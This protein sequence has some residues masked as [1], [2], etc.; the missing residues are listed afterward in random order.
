MLLWCR[1]IVGVH[2]F[3]NELIAHT[4]EVLPQIISEKRRPI[5][6]RYRSLFFVFHCHTTTVPH[7]QGP[8]KG[9]REP[10]AGVKT[11]GDRHVSSD[12][13]EQ[14]RNGERRRRPKAKASAKQP[15]EAAPGQSPEGG[16]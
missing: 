3:R 16:A 5:L 13:Q 15:D 7:F 6:R 9:S 8:F 4:F 10:I 2:V 14:E 11:T 1:V 12:R